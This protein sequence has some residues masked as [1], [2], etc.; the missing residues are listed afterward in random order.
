MTQL[1]FEMNAYDIN[2]R[3]ADEGRIP[4]VPLVHVHELRN[5][6]RSCRT[7]M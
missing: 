5:G 6:G 3:I 2:T 1:F 4:L 7:R